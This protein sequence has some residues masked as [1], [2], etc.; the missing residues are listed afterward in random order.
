MVY[1]NY[2]SKK[3]GGKQV[4]EKGLSILEMRWD[5]KGRNIKH[6]L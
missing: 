3:L 5:K 2:I 1:G 6:L 4:K